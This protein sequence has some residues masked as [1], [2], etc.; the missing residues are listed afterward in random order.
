[1][2][3]ARAAAV[4]IS[5]LTHVCANT[6]V[7]PFLHL[8]PPTPKVSRARAVAVAAEQPALVTVPGPVLE[9]RLKTLAELLKVPLVKVG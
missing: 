5:L 3:R 4:A 1:M 9:E 6:H 2:F 8:S 7:L